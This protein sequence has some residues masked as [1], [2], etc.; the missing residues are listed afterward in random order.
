MTT[1]SWWNLLWCL[2][3]IAMVCGLYVRWHS[4][5][6]DVLVSSA[7]MVI[8]LIGV[9]YLLV[10]LFNTPSPWISLGVISVMLSAASWIAVRP[11]KGLAGYLPAAALGLFVS[12][13]LH[14]F[15]S[16][17]MVLGVEHWYTP[18]VLIPLAG[19][20]FAS[21][22]NAISLCAERYH[23]EIGQNQSIHQARFTA[24]NTAMIPQ[25]NSLLA[26]GL[27]ALPGMMTGQ[28]L[29]GVSPLIAVRYQI[30]IM[31]MLLGSSGLGIAVFLLWM[32]RQ[33]TSSS[34]A[35]KKTAD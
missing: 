3:P 10:F 19:M 14:L 5:P 22:M 6:K 13:A 15:L 26:V 16:L 20:Y 33:H 2:L 29:S 27:V 35:A 7:R 12:V 8:Q 1:I 25:I 31:A 11:V 18:N 21:T 17:K 4:N 9:G 23:T 32:A 28:I 24:F 34:P 30:M